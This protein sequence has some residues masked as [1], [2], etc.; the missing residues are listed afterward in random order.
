[1][2][3]SQGADVASLLKQ[4]L[5]KNQVRAVLQVQ[6]TERSGAGVFVRIHTAVALAGGS[7]WDEPAV[8]AALTN[9]VRP[10][11]TASQLG[12]GWRQANGYFE[13]DGLQTLLAAARGKYLLVSDDSALISGM[14]ANVNRKPNVQPTVFAAGF[15][16]KL[17]RANFNR[18][19]AVVDRP[20]AGLFGN[21][22]IQRQPQ[23][24]S[25]NLASFSATLAAVSSENIVVRDAGD[26]VLQT[27]TY[28]WSQ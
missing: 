2:R 4:L 11:L 25:E 24:F 9:F 14:L 15:N 6:S 5:Q 28:Q 27:V 19:A 26:K 21:L 23:F 3:R 17:E 16:H 22:G 13:F 20:D 1:M 18:F 10:N 7:D 8:R 12:V